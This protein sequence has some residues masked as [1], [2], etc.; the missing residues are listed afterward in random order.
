M[1]ESNN[2]MNG[3]DFVIGALLGGIIGA[4]VALLLAPKSGR[5]LRVDLSDGYQTAAKKTQALAKNMGEQTET[6]VG[7]VKEVASN[8]K[9]DV[10]RW[11]ASSAEGLKDVQE[12]TTVTVQKLT[13]ETVAA[14]DEVKEKVEEAKK[15]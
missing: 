12:E 8:V 15:E 13:E 6:L 3:K 4:G 2:N 7:K 14:L 1:G 10:T 5:E 9:E 11:K